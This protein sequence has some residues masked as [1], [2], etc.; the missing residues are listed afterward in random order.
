M[1]LLEQRGSDRCRYTVV[2][3]SA[4]L[5]PDYPSRRVDACSTDTSISFAEVTFRSLLLEQ[6]VRRLFKEL[7][8]GPLMHID[9]VLDVAVAQHEV[10]A[11]LNGYQVLRRQI[12]YHVDVLDVLV[13]ILDVQ[14]ECLLVKYC[15]CSV[16]VLVSPPPHFDH[17]FHKRDNEFGML[18]SHLLGARDDGGNVG[19]L[20]G[21]VWIPG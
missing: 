5:P 17:A 15:S 3:P 20:Q 6:L 10:L 1:S 16:L 21:P 13:R 11:D 14:V 12:G 4:D 19:H 8:C 2:H 18:H 7:R 9:V